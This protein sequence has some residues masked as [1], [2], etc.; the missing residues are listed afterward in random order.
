M[1]SIDSAHAGLVPASLKS[2][3]VSTP[4][5]MLFIIGS[6]VARLGTFILPG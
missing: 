6:Y 3:L 2:L 1:N 5:R 4:D